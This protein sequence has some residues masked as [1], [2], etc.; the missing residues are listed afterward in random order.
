MNTDEL[1]QHLTNI[2]IHGAT[3]STELSHAIAIEYKKVFPESH[4]NLGCGACRKDMCQTF[5]NYFN[6]NTPS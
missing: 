1:K 5:Y 2:V 6:A 3:P 4:V